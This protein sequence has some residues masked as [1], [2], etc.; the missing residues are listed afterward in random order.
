MVTAMA[1]NGVDFGI[2]VSGT[3]DTWFTAPAPLM[4]DSSESVE[5]PAPAGK[6]PRDLGQSGEDMRRDPLS[7]AVMPVKLGKGSVTIT[8]NKAMLSDPRTKFPVYIDPETDTRRA[9]DLG[10]GHSFLEMEAF[11]ADWRS[12]LPPS[13]IEAIEARLGPERAAQVLGYP[14]W[15]LQGF[16]NTSP[17]RTSRQPTSL[18]RRPR[19]RRRQLPKATAQSR[20]DSG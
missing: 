17:A 11:D 19:S 10:N 2:R 15:R 14:D 9:Y 6:Q 3:G 18:R 5:S 7:R 1:R 4:W 12:E 13:Y 20:R 16:P 8:P